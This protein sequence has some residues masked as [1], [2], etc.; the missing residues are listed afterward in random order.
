MVTCCLLLVHPNAI[1]EQETSYKK[2]YS[3]RANL[4]NLA[5]RLFADVEH[6]AKGGS[7]DLKGK[8]QGG[9]GQAW[10]EC[11]VGLAG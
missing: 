5:K 10:D 6:V 2:R 8:D 3:E 1:T 9:E 4:A 11:E 7:E